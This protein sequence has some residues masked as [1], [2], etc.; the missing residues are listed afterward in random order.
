MQQRQ[1]EKYRKMREELQER[2]KKMDELVT[3]TVVVEKG[4]EKQFVL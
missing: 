3:Q 1:I 2:K 4:Q